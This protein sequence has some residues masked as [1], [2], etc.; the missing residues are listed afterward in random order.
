MILLK[1]S[2][3][4]GKLTTVTG[5]FGGSVNLLKTTM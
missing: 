3:N 4:K 2:D 5:L 1:I